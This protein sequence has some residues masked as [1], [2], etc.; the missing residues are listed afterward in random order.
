MRTVVGNLGSQA[1]AACVDVTRRNGEP[2]CV[3]HGGTRS[4]G[5]DP[6]ALC[7]R[8]QDQGIGE[9]VLQSVDQDGRRQ[10]YDL[11]LIEQ[12][13][14]RLA[15]PVVAL[16]GAGDVAH[17]A[18]GLR[19]GASAVASGS[20]FSFIGRLRAVLVTYPEPGVVDQLAGARA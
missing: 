4:T 20:A 15:V 6:L 12:I 19:H 13:S 9:I 16:G 10:G 3:T 18:D 17:L 14:H 7:R 11:P 1:V 8:L 5:L 2:V